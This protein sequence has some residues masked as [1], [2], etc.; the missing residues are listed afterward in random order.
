MKIE[1][2]RA[3]SSFTT[4]FQYTFM[5]QTIYKSLYSRT[6]HNLGYQY[7]VVFYKD[8][9]FAKPS[10]RLPAICLRTHECS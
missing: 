1:N 4:M 6:M 9:S 10:S 8:V 7:I 3:N 2:V 5:Y